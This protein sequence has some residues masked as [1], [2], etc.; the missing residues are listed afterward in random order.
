MRLIGMES[1]RPGSVRAPRRVPRVGGEAVWQ[2]MTHP[3]WTFALRA[4]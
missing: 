2:L 1:R 3:S 4:R